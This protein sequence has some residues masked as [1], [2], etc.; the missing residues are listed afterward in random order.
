[1]IKEDN[2]I[3]AFL[4]CFLETKNNYLL[5]HVIYSYK[6]IRTYS[7]INLPLVLILCNIIK[8]LYKSKSIR[9][10]YI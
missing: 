8:I 3:L 4:L 1:M 2:K 6:I 10:S 9:F 5:Q 7:I